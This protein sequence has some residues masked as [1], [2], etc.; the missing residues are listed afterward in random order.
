MEQQTFYD[1]PVLRM[2]AIP[3]IDIEVMRSG[4]TPFP[5]GELSV[6]AVIPAIS[7]AMLSLTGVRLRNAPFTAERV[8]QAL[9]ARA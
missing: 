9:G 2:S 8:K 3:Q 4:D 5:V 7:N 1:Y 6:S